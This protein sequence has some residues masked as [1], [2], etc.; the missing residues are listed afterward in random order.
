[1]QSLILKK[2]VTFEL[3]GA[4]LVCAVRIT[5]NPLLLKGFK[6]TENWRFQHPSGSTTGN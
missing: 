1:M 3:N 2:Q 4:F 6:N 5:I